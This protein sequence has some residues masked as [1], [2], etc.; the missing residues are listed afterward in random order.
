[1]NTLFAKTHAWQQLLQDAVTCPRELLALLE[2]HENQLAWISNDA[3][4][5]KLK[6]P[7]GFVD[8]MQKRNPDDPLLKQVFP[9]TQELT[10]TPTYKN[11]P[12]EE[13]SFNPLPGLLHK[14]TNRVLLTVVGACAINCRFCFRRHFDYPDNNPGRAGWAKIIDYIKERPQI[15]E[16]ILSGGDPLVAGDD[17]LA[18]LSRALSE[19]PHVDTLRIHTRIPIV[20]PERITPE[21]LAWFTQSRL[22]PVLVTHCNHPQEID[23][24]VTCALQLLKEA[25]VCLLNQTVLLKG[26][27][28]NAAIL[29]ALSK[30]LFKMGVQPYYLHI[31][32]EV[33]GTAHFEV[34]TATAKVIYAE[35]MGLVSGYLLPKL[36]QEIPG[37]K[38]K[39]FV[40]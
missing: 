16:V 29:A 5:F 10:L 7:R 24:K 28:D 6:V 20:L 38:S 3:L 8:R 14:Y 15:N 27:N 40:T 1:M 18:D 39:S 4:T 25:N 34:S 32:D 33:Q 26:I 21:F 31:T 13:T 19:I 11:D 35:L 23:E 2:L 22:Q 12:L 17:L 9:L 37:E 36:V 30:I